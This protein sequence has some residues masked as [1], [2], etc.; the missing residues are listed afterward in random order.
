MSD[1]RVFDYEQIAAIY[2]EMNQ[3]TGDASDPTSIAG[4]LNK[5]D[6]DYKEVVNGSA[7]E[8]ALAL[9]GDL[10]SQMLLNWENTAAT[11][12]AFVENF[13]AWSTAVAQTAGDYSSFETQVKGIRTDNPLGWNSGGIKDSYVASSIYAN[14]LTHEELDNAAASAQMYN[15]VGAYY[16]DTG[17]VSAAK[18]SAFWNGVTDILSVAGIVASGF[19]IANTVG[20]LTSGAAGA[21]GAGGNAINQVGGEAAEQGARLL[22]PG[23]A[24]DAGRLLLESGDDA[25]RLLLESGDDAGRLLLE[26]GDDTGRLL[27]ESGD[28]YVKMGIVEGTDDVANLTYNEALHNVRTGNAD[29]N[30]IWKLAQSYGSGPGG[31]AITANPGSFNHA[32]QVAASMG[33]KILNGTA[34]A[35]DKEL[36]LGSIYRISGDLTAEQFDDFMIDVA[37]HYSGSAAQSMGSVVGG[38]V[39]DDVAG[40]IVNSTVA[41][42][43]IANGSVN[44]G[45]R[46]ASNF[47]SQ[48]GDD[49]VE[50]VDDSV[51]DATGN[52]VD[53]LDSNGNVIASDVYRNG[54]FSSTIPSNAS[55]S[56]GTASN[57][58]GAASNV[59]RNASTNGNLATGI[60]V[61]ASAGSTISLNTNMGRAAE[62]I[63][64]TQ[65]S[66]VGS[67]G[68]RNPSID[69]A[70]NSS[71]G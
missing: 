61:A 7:G 38:N 2:K 17:M 68:L 69:I 13:S 49:L 45:V 9:Y 30:S 29:A 46:S 70:D 12:P 25:G 18:K 50:I 47:A 33:K 19:S 60:G 24:D 32:E 42:N 22:G 6:Q 16:V 66:S 14:S 62:I 4:L 44:Q 34:T 39:V 40:N 10:G 56:F 15:L 26:S 43:P 64:N 20:A 8:D 58:S 31:T 1:T 59:I 71:Q 21:A 27:L 37:Q 41:A 55:S 3:I 57:S 48:Y 63:A 23:A 28:D 36:F 54:S 11:F 53:I 35:A 51:V 67:G 5:I 65:W 52:V